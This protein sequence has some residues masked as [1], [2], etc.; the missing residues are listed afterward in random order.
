MREVHGRMHSRNSISVSLQRPFS[1]SLLY[2][3]VALALTD[4]SRLMHAGSSSQEKFFVCISTHVA[5][6]F[7]GKIGFGVDEIDENPGIQY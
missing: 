7:S 2:I 6:S 1:V 5:L 4:L 3:S